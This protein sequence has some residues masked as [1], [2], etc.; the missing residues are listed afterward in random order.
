M[1]ERVWGTGSAAVSLEPA[2]ESTGDLEYDEDDPEFYAG[3]REVL[4]LHDAPSMGA[5][6][7]GDG[8]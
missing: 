4:D 6:P 7:E 2:G 1:Y 5:L 8:D 3:D